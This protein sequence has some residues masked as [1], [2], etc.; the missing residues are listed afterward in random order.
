MMRARIKCPRFAA[1]II[2]LTTAV[3]AAAQPIATQQ[4]LD[5]GDRLELFTDGQIIERM[6]HM[7][8]H[9]HAPE[10]AGVAL[11]FDRPYEGPY[12][13]Y[14]TIVHD[15][16]ARLYRMYYRGILTRE[17]GKLHD[18]GAEVTCYAESPDGVHWVK[19]DLELVEVN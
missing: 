19:P 9:L 2:S 13:A 3:A 1:L 4:P 12:A 18:P 8:L 15:Q 7:D 11:R 17:T 10:P 14:A 6:E 5:I 16:S